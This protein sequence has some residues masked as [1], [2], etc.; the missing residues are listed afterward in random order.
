MYAH[1]A[2]TLIVLFGHGAAMACE[3][4]AEAPARAGTAPLLIA[5]SHVSDP[6]LR[7]ASDAP[8]LVIG[9]IGADAPTMMRTSG[10]PDPIVRF[11]P[12]EERASARSAP[13]AAPAADADR[14]NGATLLLVGLALMAGIAM[15]RRGAGRP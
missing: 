1:L 11:N 6:M 5:Q 15:R 4:A 2:A 8:A 7:T 9:Q 12:R 10:R 3:Q 13:A 14:G